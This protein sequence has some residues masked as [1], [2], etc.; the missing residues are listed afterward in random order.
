MPQQQHGSDMMQ[1]YQNHPQLGGSVQN[2]RHPGHVYP[3]PATY[4]GVHTPYEPPPELV[5][6]G[7]ASR[8][9]NLDA[10]WTSLMHESGFLDDVN[11]RT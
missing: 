9:G 6:L 11:F 10:R 8:E 3:G 7:L 1:S 2:F 5:N 4:Q